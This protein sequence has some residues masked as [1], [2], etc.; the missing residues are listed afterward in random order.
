MYRKTLTYSIKYYFLSAKNWVLLFTAL[1]CT[2]YPL[3]FTKTPSIS[4]C[5]FDEDN[6]IESQQV[7]EILKGNEGITF[8]EYSREE[9]ER[10]L[11]T[12]GIEALFVIE[13]GFAAKLQ[14]GDFTHTVFMQLS[15]YSRGGGTITEAVAAAVMEIYAKNVAKN[16]V[17]NVTKDVSLGEKAALRTEG[18]DLVLIGLNETGLTKAQ[19]TSGAKGSLLFLTSLLC[20]Y[21]LCFVMKPSQAISDKCLSGGYSF[22]G[23]TFLYNYGK[24]LPVALLSIIPLL[25]GGYDVAHAAL[26]LAY[27][28]V[29]CLLSVLLVGLKTTLRLNIAVYYSLLNAVFALSGMFEGGIA[30][31]FPGYIIARLL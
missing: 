5:L 8:I 29:V 19:A 24:L 12:G 20:A 26:V 27:S 7:A 3:I 9:A 31:L 25:V 13:P 15:K 18:S 30:Y 4:V 1:L 21:A 14:S 10:F 11:E 22:F 16:A 17:V 28:L 6:S 2:L 23:I